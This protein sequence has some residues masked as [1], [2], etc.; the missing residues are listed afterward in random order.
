MSY[1]EYY[2]IRYFL[3]VLKLIGSGFTAFDKVPP[4]ILTYLLKSFF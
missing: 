4:H 1:V 2:P 3:R